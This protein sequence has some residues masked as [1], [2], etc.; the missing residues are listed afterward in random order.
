V[1]LVCDT[2]VLVIVLRSF[3]RIAIV[4]PQALVEFLDRT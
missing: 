1:K 3:E 2:N 4:S